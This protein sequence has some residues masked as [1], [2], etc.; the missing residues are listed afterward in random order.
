MGGWVGWVILQENDESLIWV[1]KIFHHELV[2]FLRFSVVRLVVHFSDNSVFLNNEFGGQGWGIYIL[3]N[4]PPPRM[5]V[6]TRIIPFLGS[7]IPN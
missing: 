6:T 3:W 7:G 5:P 1:V 4:Y 2:D